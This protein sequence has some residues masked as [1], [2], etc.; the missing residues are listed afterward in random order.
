VGN[1]EQKVAKGVLVAGKRLCS[2]PHKKEETD[3]NV[4]AAKLSQDD[5]IKDATTYA[6][7]AQLESPS[8]QES[9]EEEAVVTQEEEVVAPGTGDKNLNLFML[10]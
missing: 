7:T 2:L 4:P 9:A 10:L 8:R 6:Y 5:A 1:K 3:A